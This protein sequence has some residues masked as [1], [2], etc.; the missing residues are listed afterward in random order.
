MRT[1]WGS[2]EP[3]CLPCCLSPFSLT[4]WV[5]LS[6]GNLETAAPVQTP[7]LAFK[8]PVSV[9]G[10]FSLFPE[11]RFVSLDSALLHLTNSHP[12]F[13]VT[14]SCFQTGMAFLL[15]ILDTEFTTNA[16]QATSNGCHLCDKRLVRAWWLLLCF[17]L[18]SHFPEKKKKQQQQ[19]IR[20]EVILI[21]SLY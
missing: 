10:N 3:S 8:F 4:C 16:A 18:L 6:L 13:T 7:Q 9:G 21:L 1:H 2:P 19:N 5:E 20:I 12:Y 11:R 17:S 15:V 14:F